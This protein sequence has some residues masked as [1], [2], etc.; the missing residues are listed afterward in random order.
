MWRL[1]DISMFV[2]E[3]RRQTNEWQHSRWRVHVTSRFEMSVGVMQQAERPC[4]PM[5]IHKKSP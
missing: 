1:W 2:F 3:Q 4:F 5:D